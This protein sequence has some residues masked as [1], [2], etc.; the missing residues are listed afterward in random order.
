[1]L[2]GV[3]LGRCSFW[4][5]TF[6]YCDVIRSMSFHPMNVAD[7]R[8]SRRGIRTALMMNM[9]CLSV[10]AFLLSRLQIVLVSF[11]AS[12]LVAFDFP[13]AENHTPKI[14]DALLASCGLTLA[15]P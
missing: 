15:P 9:H 13:S 1:M 11:I 14:L 2:L 7:S 6:L 8:Y 12:S 10:T 4:R 3:E 5:T